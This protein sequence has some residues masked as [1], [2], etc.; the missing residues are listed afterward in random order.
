MDNG[1]LLSQFRN[2]FVIDATQKYGRNRGRLRLEENVG[3]KTEKRMETLRPR[4][5]TMGRRGD[6]HVLFRYSDRR[7]AHDFVSSPACEI[8]WPEPSPENHPQGLKCL[9][10]LAEP[11]KR[12]AEPALKLRAYSTCMLLG[13]G[14][15][16]GGPVRRCQEDYSLERSRSGPHSFRR[17]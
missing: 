14:D 5:V 9:M 17:L 16:N 6:F 8:L 2:T 13:P 11:L 15:A 3:Q 12:K 1:F 4:M 7:K 10:F